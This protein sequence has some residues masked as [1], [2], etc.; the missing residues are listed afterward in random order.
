[1]NYVKKYYNSINNGEIIACKEV[2]E[3]YKRMCE[4]MDLNINNPFLFYFDENV[5]N[6]A[7]EFIET[8]C[9]HYEGAK[10]GELVVLELFQKAFI[11]NLFGW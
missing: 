8:F 6:H 10:A 3:I 4:E 7:V 1:M 9:R 2:T 11:Q 5:G